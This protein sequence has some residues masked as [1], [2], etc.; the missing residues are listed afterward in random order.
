[1]NCDSKAL[2]LFLYF[3]VFFE[4]IAPRVCGGRDGKTNNAG[5]SSKRF[6]AI[7]EESR[8]ADTQRVIR[9]GWLA[10]T[11]GGTVLRSVP[12]ILLGVNPDAKI[13]EI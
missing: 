7:Q 8:R 12:I 4:G 2:K 11:F 1:M 6:D 10:N 9:R 3:L 5:Q 13:F